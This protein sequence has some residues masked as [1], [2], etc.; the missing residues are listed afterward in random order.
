MNKSCK[1]GISIAGACLMLVLVFAYNQWQMGATQQRPSLEN[2]SQ[3]SLQHQPPQPQKVLAADV[4]VLQIVTGSYNAT[5]TAY[6]NTESRYGLT[7]QAQVG[8][9]ISG[10]SAQLETGQLIKTGDVLVE[11]DSRDYEAALATAKAELSSA[12]VALLEEQRQGEQAALEWQSAG[13]EDAPDSE[14]VLRRPQLESAQAAYNQAKAAVVSAQRDLE[15]TQV[16]APFN[17]LVIERLIAPGSLV[18]EGT[19]LATLYSSD[20][21]EVTINLTA[22][23]WKNLP[24]RFDEPGQWPADIVAVDGSGRW[25]AYVSRQS[26]HLDTETRQRALVLQINNPLAQNPPLYPGQFVQASLSGIAQSGLWKLPV[27]ALSQRSEI[28]FVT[29][30]NTLDSFGATI[31]FSDTDAIYLRPPASLSSTPQLVL[32]RPLNSYLQGMKVNP[33]RQEDRENQIGIGSSN[34][35]RRGDQHNG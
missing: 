24:A 16:K 25:S 2:N 31:L 6:G 3:N 21:M 27:S 13:L 8:G 22:S 28:W 19:E 33:V 18:Q 9:Q 30:E 35:A 4:A 7:L 20:E 12:R 23:D 11:L 26:S 32:I 10:L 29:A 1:Q 34:N 17:A 15:N 14:L 5:I